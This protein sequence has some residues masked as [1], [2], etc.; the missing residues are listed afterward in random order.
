[1][2]IKTM[3]PEELEQRKAAIAIEVDQEGADLDAL[4][5]EARSINEEL[6]QRKAE[7]S[8][9]DE[10]RKAVAASDVPGM[11]PVKEERKV[12]TLEEIR[13]SQA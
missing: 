6:E 13:S 7:A 2:D 9:R 10:I 3:T 1:M 11:N 5:A 12:Q 4:Q 8:K